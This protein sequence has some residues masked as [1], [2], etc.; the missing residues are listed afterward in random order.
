MRKSSKMEI[1]TNASEKITYP[2]QKN[3]KSSIYSK[4]KKLLRGIQQNKSNAQCEGD[5][6][7]HSLEKRLSQL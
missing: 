2:L 5:V 4:I 1:A 3:R 7:F 6:L